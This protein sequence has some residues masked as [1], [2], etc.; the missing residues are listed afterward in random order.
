MLGS[1]DGYE[2]TVTVKQYPFAFTSGYRAAA[3]AFG[4]TP[5]RALVSIDDESGELVARYGPWVVRTSVA[6]VKRAQLTGPYGIAKT[7]GPAHLSFKD[8]GLTMASNRN[9]GV[10]MTFVE[11]VQGIDPAG[12]IKHPGLTVTVADCDGL[13]AALNR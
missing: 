11:P 1:W 10:C 13:L 4:V 6:N 12:L 9:R 5:G 7:I 8:R 2:P 3:T